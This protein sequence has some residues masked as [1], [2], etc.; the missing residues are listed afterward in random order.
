MN[1]IHFM[2]VNKIAISHVLRTQHQE[3]DAG[4]GEAVMEF[5]LPQTDDMSV[6][7]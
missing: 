4:Y 2:D 7:P 5:M 6:N 3:V 1:E